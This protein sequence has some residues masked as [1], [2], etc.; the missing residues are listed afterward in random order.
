MRIIE[1][2]IY[3]LFIY[4]FNSYIN[5]IIKGYIIGE[6]INPRSVIIQTVHY[7]LYYSL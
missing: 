3:K 6:V 7:I 5:S 2:V 4:V 1:I